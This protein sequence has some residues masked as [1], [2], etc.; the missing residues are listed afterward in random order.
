MEER[1]EGKEEVTIKDVHRNY[2]VG[3]PKHNYSC[4]ILHRGSN[5]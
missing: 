1:M 5:N 3:A 2:L 4:C